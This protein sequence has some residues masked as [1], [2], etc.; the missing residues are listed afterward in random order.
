[1]EA[2]KP[3]LARL[4]R[5]T[6]LVDRGFQLKY[7]VTLGV[8]AAAI[9]ALFGGMMYLAHAQARAGFDTF[10]LR[11]GAKMPPELE[12]QLAEIDTTLWSLMAATVV[13]MAVAL[14]LFGVL[15][16]HRVAGPVH[17]M[18]HYISVL[19]KGRYPIM[20]P[21]RKS[22]ELKSFF[23]RFSQAVESLRQ[24]D[25]AEADELE[26][27]LAR[28]TPLAQSPEAAQVLGGLKAMRDRKRDAT[29]RV[30]VSKA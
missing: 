19:A 21:L 8:V 28:L 13:L 27:A 14:S 6:Y 17:V 3:P 23:E 9:S 29:D 5:R 18:S 24:R 1:M 4:S 22:D 7:S 20:R 12:A 16:T 15:V 25:A 2:A 10:F 11:F 30:T 26:E